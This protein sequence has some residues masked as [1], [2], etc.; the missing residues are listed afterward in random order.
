MILPYNIIVVTSVLIAI[1]IQF[2]SGVNSVWHVE[3]QTVGR[4]VGD[5]YDEWRGQ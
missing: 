4:G 1:L 2:C 3:W 5:I